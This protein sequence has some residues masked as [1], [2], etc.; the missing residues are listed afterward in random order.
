[1]MSDDRQKIIDNISSTTLT[2][3]DENLLGDIKK[4]VS[5]NQSIKEQMILIKDDNDE[6]RNQLQVQQQQKLKSENECKQAIR[7][8]SEIIEC[9][10]SSSTE[11]REKLDEKI[12]S[13]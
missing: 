12:R 8:V 3:G 1:M 2:D 4:V 5:E 6:L 9:P 7:A 11:L 13:L 10:I